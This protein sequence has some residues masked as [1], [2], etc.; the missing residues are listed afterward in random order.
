MDKSNCDKIKKWLLERCSKT[1]LKTILDIRTIICS[2]GHCTQNSS[3]SHRRLTK[4]NL[5]KMGTYDTKLD[6]ISNELIKVLIQEEEKR[7]KKRADAVNERYTNP[8]PTDKNFIRFVKE[9]K[10]EKNNDCKVERTPIEEIFSLIDEI[11]E[12]NGN[13]I[14]SLRVNKAPGQK[15]TQINKC[16]MSYGDINYLG[17]N[18]ALF[19]FDRGIRGIQTY[20][21]SM[22]PL[23]KQP[24]YKDRVVIDD[25]VFT[26]DC[27]CDSANQ[28]KE[29]FPH[30]RVTIAPGLTCPKRLNQMERIIFARNKNATNQFFMTARSMLIRY[31]R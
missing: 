6:T 14:L 23:E 12:E 25:I 15:I 13:T 28:H 18:K 1:K 30:Y 9:T 10:T 4:Y 22:Y 31:W 20:T 7:D 19:Y 16:R 17:N 26:S 21:N 27:K 29:M 24:P 8:R 2:K 5:G 11:A 3:R